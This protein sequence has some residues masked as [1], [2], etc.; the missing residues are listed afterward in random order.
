MELDHVLIAVTDLEA[1]AHEFE[2]RGLSSVEGGRHRDWG[3]ANRIV[4]LGSC[5]IEL[6]AVVDAAVA[7]DSAFGRWVA[8]GANPEGRPIGW[9]VRTS[10]LDDVAGRLDLV[11]R[12]GSRVTPIRRGVALAKRRCRRGHRRTVPAV[13]HRVGRGR[14][15][16]R[17]GGP[18]A[19]NDL[20]A[21]ARGQ[22]GSSGGMA[23]RAF[24]ADSSAQRSRRGRRGGAVDVR[25]R[26]HLVSGDGAPAKPG[27]RAQQILRA[28]LPA[29]VVLLVV[30]LVDVAAALVI[31]GEQV[32]LTI[33]QA[34]FGLL[35]ALILIVSGYQ[36]RKHLAD[37]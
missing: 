9:A 25:G 37:G 23:R 2:R 4:P 3:T 32:G 36:Y 27:R 16:A 31:G 20:Q 14:T 11:V 15:A 12:S 26:D 29:G 33:A 30:W 10:G 35:T 28:V 1:A 5:Y 6:I 17:D 19:G 8:G 21:R 7:A 34:V 24:T 18:S 22:S 13:L